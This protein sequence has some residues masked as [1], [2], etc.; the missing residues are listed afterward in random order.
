M[1]SW[2]IWIKCVLLGAAQA[3]QQKSPYSRPSN[4]LEFPRTEACL[5][6]ML[7]QSLSHELFCPSTMGFVP[8]AI[9]HHEMWAPSKTG[10]IIL[11]VSRLPPQV[12]YL[13]HTPDPVR[14]AASTDLPSVMGHGTHTAGRKQAPG[15]TPTLQ[16]TLGKPRRPSLPEFSQLWTWIK[17]FFEVYPDPLIKDKDFKTWFLTAHSSEHELRLW[18][19]KS[20]STP[21]VLTLPQRE[22][23]KTPHRLIITGTGKIHFGCWYTLRFWQVCVLFLNTVANCS[24]FKELFSTAQGY[25]GGKPTSGHITPCPWEHFSGLIWSWVD[26]EDTQLGFWTSSSTPQALTNVF[27]LPGRV[28]IFLL[29]RM[30]SC[31]EYLHWL[32]A[33]IFF[34][35]LRSLK[36]HII[37]VLKHWWSTEHAQPQLGAGRVLLMSL[38]ST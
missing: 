29:R 12:P 18:H 24:E 38:L 4:V 9:V 36:D 10:L 32:W 25:L 21:Q 26:C 5:L 37:F 15:L 30:N 23:N 14:P 8:P 17:M 31:H 35:L 2:L 16:I 6:P 1:C 33:I 34:V 28:L 20:S 27:Y 13:T 7:I 11:N 19:G 3:K 22:N